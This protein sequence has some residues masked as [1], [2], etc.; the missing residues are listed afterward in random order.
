VITQ[1]KLVVKGFD[2]GK[3][4]PLEN[5]QIDALSICKLANLA[6]QWDNE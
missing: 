5:Y 3:Q 4:R 1:D 6:K 2:F